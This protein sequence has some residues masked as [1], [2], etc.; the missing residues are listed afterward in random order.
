[1][2]ASFFNGSL[3]ASCGGGG[4]YNFNNSAR[5]GHTGSKACND[6]SAHVNWDGIYLTEAAYRHIA[7][8]FISGPFSTAPLVLSPLRQSRA[9][10]LNAWHT[11]MQ[12]QEEEKNWHDSMDNGTIIRFVRSKRSGLCLFIYLFLFFGFNLLSLL[13]LFGGFKV[14]LF[15]LV[16][17]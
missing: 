16:G 7:K 13:C 8:G 14:S 15:S 12:N 3:T 6:P 11:K 1:M 10:Y 4:P 17:H 2:N 5:C 9:N